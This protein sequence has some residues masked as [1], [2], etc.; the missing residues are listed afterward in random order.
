MNGAG[1][2]LPPAQRPP[3][4][5]PACSGACRV[6]RRVGRQQGSP[7]SQARTWAW[8]RG[9]QLTVSFLWT[10]ALSPAQPSVA[11]RSSPR[12][13]GLISRRHPVIQATQTR[14]PLPA[15][16]WY[17]IWAWGTSY[18]A[19]W[20]LEASVAINMGG[21]GASC[22]VVGCVCAIKVLLLC[23]WL[24]DNG[25]LPPTPTT[26]KK[27]SAGVLCSLIFRKCFAIH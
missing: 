23:L 6:V 26:K 10:R 7:C 11:R 18:R 8:T 20:V 17:P 4:C 24:C 21:T 5:S 14:S 19:S 1:T 16:C 15:K 25:P 22:S 2:L 12:V 27:S 13:Q 3:P 9:S